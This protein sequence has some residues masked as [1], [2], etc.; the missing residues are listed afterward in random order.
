MQ[1]VRLSSRGN[2]VASMPF[3]DRQ[4]P[5]S[6]EAEVSVLGGM[7]IDNDAVA[8]ALEVLTDDGMFYREGHRR[9]FRSM[10]R[11]FQKGGVVDPVTLS[12]ELSQFLLDLWSV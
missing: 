8:K 9:I 4:P 2:A 6:P 10:T 7:L 5:Y 11:I 3:G 1:N 12:E